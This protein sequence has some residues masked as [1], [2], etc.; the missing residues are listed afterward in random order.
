MYYFSYFPC[1]IIIVFFSLSLSGKDIFIEIS[2]TER[3]RE[4][5]RDKP[6]DQ[7]TFKDIHGEIH[8]NIN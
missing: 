5:E 1:K 6:A 2:M 8:K 4:R 3:E 7:S